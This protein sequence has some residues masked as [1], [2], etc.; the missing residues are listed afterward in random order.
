MRGADPDYTRWRQQELD[1]SDAMFQLGI[2][3]NDAA[4][5]NGLMNSIWAQ[6]YRALDWLDRSHCPLPHSRPSAAISTRL[7]LRICVQ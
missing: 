1:I 2:V 3:D 5:Q 6:R 4:K 7:A